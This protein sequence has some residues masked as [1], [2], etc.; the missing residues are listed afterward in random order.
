MTKQQAEALR[1]FHE[2]ARDWAAMAAQT[3]PDTVNVIRQRNDF[4][5]E[6]ARQRAV[7]TALDVGSGSGDLVCDLAARGVA[8]HGVDFAPDMVALATEQASRRALP[9]ATFECRS[10]FERDPSGRS[11]DLV[12]ANG[13][14]E[15]ISP[16]ELQRFVSLCN[17]LLVPGGSLVVGSRNR[18]FNVVSLNAFTEGELGRGTIAALLAEAVA[19]AAGR[20]LAELMELPTPP[21]E[22]GVQLH[23]HTGVD[24][25]TRH[26]FTPV[27]L[28]RVLVA[29]HFEPQQ[30]YPIHVHGV[31]PTF[32]A[33][34]P[35]T[36]AAIANLLQTFAAEGSGLVP[37]ASSF[38]LH[39]VRCP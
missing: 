19:L 28:A 21:P 32:K 1:Y 33:T 13:F 24:V 38:M 37:F 16:D 36:H 2:H 14:I 25:Q 39:A 17:Q 6:V 4:V 9:Q 8:A 30:L 18:L 31:P 15:Y 34:H 26:Q 11:Y 3:G 7:R 12:S 35:E 23:P 5:L 29:H 10:I 27:Q 20:R 22:E